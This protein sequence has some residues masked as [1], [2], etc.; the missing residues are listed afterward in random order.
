MCS[1]CCRHIVH[2]SHWLYSAYHPDEPLDCLPVLVAVV[3]ERDLVVLVVLL[4]KIQL[5]A[6]T[7]ED[8]LRLAGCV[9]NDRRDTSIGYENIR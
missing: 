4:A 5:H 1:R 3:R 7:F 2:I 8:T 6:C 9:V